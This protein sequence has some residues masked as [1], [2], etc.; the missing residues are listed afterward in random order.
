MFLNKKEKEKTP[1]KVITKMYKRIEELYNLM[2]E[3]D[4]TESLYDMTNPISY[5]SIF[6]E[7]WASRIYASNL[8]QRKI[9]IHKRNTKASIFHYEVKFEI[10]EKSKIDTVFV[11]KVFEDKTKIH[12]CPIAQTAHE[13]DLAILE[14]ENYIN[15]I[16]A[17]HKEKQDE[18]SL[19]NQEQQ[20]LNLIERKLKENDR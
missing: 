14:F 16:Y 4:Y 1:Q 20:D 18:L 15:K 13:I 12:P 6:C 5:R 11:L 7:A 19:L 2:F 8:G 9:I 3:L 17:E 10:F